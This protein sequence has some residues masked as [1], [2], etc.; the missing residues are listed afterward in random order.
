MPMEQFIAL[1]VDFRACSDK[2]GI[3]L[4][5]KESVVRHGFSLRYILLGT[6]LG[7]VFFLSGCSSP[8]P[9]TGKPVAEVTPLPTEPVDTNATPESLIADAQTVWEEQRDSL[10]RNNLLLQAVELLLENNDIARAQQILLQLQQDNVDERLQTRMNVLSALAWAD[11]A[12]TDALLTLLETP[13]DDDA[14]HYKQLDLQTALYLRKGDLLSAAN[15]YEQ[16]MPPSDE[17]VRQVWSW[18]NES[19]Y[20]LPDDAQSE[21]PA[22]RPY[23][24]LLELV[25][26]NGLSPQSLASATEQFKQVYRG[27]RLVDHWPEEVTLAS[28]LQPETIP[29]ILVML[30]LS[31]RLENTGMAIKEGILSA[32][33][34]A[35]QNASDT[36]DVPQLEFVDTVSKSPQELAESVG[37]HR[38]VIGPLLKETIEAV[39]PL[40]PHNVNVLALNRADLNAEKPPVGMLEPFTTP[41]EE[42]RIQTEPGFFSL[43]PE[44]EAYQ[45][46]DHI[47][48]SGYRAPI[49]V[50]AQSSIYQRMNDAFSQRWQT[51]NTRHASKDKVNLTSI[52][53]SDSTTLREGITQAL[54]VAQSK[55]RINQIRYMVN[56]ELYNVPRSRG[57]IDAI[58]VFA[59]PE[60]TEL[61]NPMVEASLSPF[62]GKV[63]P[64]YAT[65]RSMEYDSSKNQWRDLQNV[66]FLDMPWMM[67]DN[68]WQALQS[69]SETLWPHRG[70]QLNR[71][72]AFGV[73]AY[74]LLPSLHTMGLLPQVEVAGLTGTLSMNDD[75]QIERRLP[76]AKID[77]E[78]VIPLSN[79]K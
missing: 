24:A 79:K 3:E 56:E 51:L 61:L 23:L 21:Y 7:T 72:F 18:V 63:V 39:V 31:G 11:A 38:W 20:Q 46:A 64:V 50:A 2:L 62:D 73:D 41:M 42:T 70:T 66:R 33:Y 6:C 15:S 4:T 44:D 8:A 5:K 19:R 16:A 67:P 27:H 29:Q 1:D 43:A 28:E 22:L 59:S 69:Q 78:R 37:Q 58:V 10:Q 14:L 47:F 49:I 9:R 17:S 36:S 12:E 77:N 30:P 25:Q 55:D 74:N 54:D 35:L 52:D 32:F 65:S 13:V 26:A 75:H 48:N 34:Q 45:L 68:Q 60:Q 57:D 53:F 71:L 76:Q 40:I